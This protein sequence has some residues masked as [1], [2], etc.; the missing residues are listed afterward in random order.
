RYAR[1]AHGL[2]RRRRC[3]A[4]NDRA[5]SACACALLVGPPLARQPQPPSSS[6]VAPDE[7]LAVAPAPPLLVP[8]ELLVMPE[9]V[10]PEPP[11]LADVALPSAPALPPA[12]VAAP[13]A[14]MP[15]VP[16]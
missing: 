11:L 2:I 9:L 12:P 10:T 14:G 1:R 8:P 4:S 6:L 13:V 15:A 3:R 5:S 16:P 7:V